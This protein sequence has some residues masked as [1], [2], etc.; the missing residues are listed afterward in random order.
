MTRDQLRALV[1]AIVDE[2]R[3]IGRAWLYRD[4]LLWLFALRGS[5]GERA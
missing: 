4:M 1:I 3:R 2:R 5:N